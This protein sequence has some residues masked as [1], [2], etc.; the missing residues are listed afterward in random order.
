MQ[1][2][3]IEGNMVHAVSPEGQKAS[4]KIQDL[5]QRSSPRRMDSCGVLI[6][7]GV[8]LMYS[9]PDGRLAV[10][11][12]ETPPCVIQLKWIASDSPVPYGQGSKYRMVRIAIPYLIVLAA[13]ENGRVSDFNECFF[14]T[15]PLESED[16]PLLYPG[17]LN[18]S[19]FHRPEGH[20]LSWICTQKLDRSQF[21]NEKNVKQRM[22]IGFRSLCHCLL[23]TGFNFSSE[24][25]EFS[26]WYS[27]S[28][29]VDPR[30]S[31][32][33]NWEKA[34]DDDPT[35]VLEVPW[36]KVGMSVKQVVERLFKNHQADSSRVSSVHDLF[37]LIFNN[38]S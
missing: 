2:V 29:K 25:H 6:P 11:V 10:W 30:V 28:A 4:I 36:L 16:D 37:R 20:P 17:L 27:E 35:F 33:E 1:N 24:H 3:T 26:S 13:F 5:F 12:H 34:T 18:C 22:R 15:D 32:I 8:R 14:R 21:M 7:D 31:P 19:K 9:D 38:A 23:E